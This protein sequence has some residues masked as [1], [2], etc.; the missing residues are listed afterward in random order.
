MVR[1]GTL[2]ELLAPR[3][4]LFYAQNWSLYKNLLDSN[5]KTDAVVIEELEK[6][7][8]IESQFLTD[9]S[10]GMDDARSRLRWASWRHTPG[11]RISHI[12]FLGFSISIYPLC[13]GNLPRRHLAVSG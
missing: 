9:F 5:H 2:Q 12:R 13:M 10:P 4:I 6:A 11:M 1:R 8:G 7:T 3:T